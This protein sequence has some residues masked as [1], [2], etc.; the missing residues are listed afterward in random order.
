MAVKEVEEVNEV[1][2][3]GMG[4]G[5]CAA[6]D[7]GGRVWVVKAEAELP[8]SKKERAAWAA[9]LAKLCWGKVTTRG[10]P[11]FGGTGV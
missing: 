8:H 5:G 6:E 4:C 9:R 7:L 11:A 3:L 2:D 10:L 1:K